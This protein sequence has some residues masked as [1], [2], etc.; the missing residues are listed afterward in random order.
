MKIRAN[1]VT[2]STRETY[3]DA[4]HNFIVPR[5]G[6]LLCK[7]VTRQALESWLVWAQSLTRKNGRPYAQDTMRQWWRVLKTVLSDMTADLDLP[8]P[9]RRLRPPQRPELP[10]VREQHTLDVKAIGDMLAACRDKYPTRLAEVATMA[11]TG[12]RA[13]EVYA[14]KWD[15]IDFAKGQIVIRR[16]LSR[17]QLL[18]RTKTKTQRVVPMHPDLAEI[19]LAHRNYQITKQ[20]AGLDLGMVFLSD[21]GQMR[22]PNSA[23]KLWPRL[24]KLAGID[25]KI[26]PQVLRRTLN[27]LMLSAQVDRIT[28]RAIMGHTSEAM[29]ARYAGIGDAAKTDAINR[30]RPTLALVPNT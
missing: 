5:L 23:K 19:L 30:I 13:G 17:G 20:V 14:L 11:L 29:T 1:R 2:P 3:E 12:A 7:D 24:A 21:D 4:L 28:L 9:T 18:E 22:D 25:Q 8:D 6:H 16:S 10:P 26:S 15:V 27:T